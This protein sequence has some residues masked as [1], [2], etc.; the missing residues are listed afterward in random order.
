MKKITSKQDLR[1]WLEYEKLNP[2]SLW[3][4]VWVNEKQ[5]I[6]KYQKLLRK[7]EY[8]LNTN[9]RIRSLLYRFR[10]SRYQ[11]KYPLSISPNTCGKGLRIIHV[12][13]ILINGNAVVGENC[14]F[15]INTALV[16]GGNTDDTPTLGNNVIM[17]IGSTVVGGVTVAD[18]VVIGAGAVVTRDV[19]EPN[20]TVAGVPARKISDGSSAG[21]KPENRKKQS[22]E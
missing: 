11:R 7:T 5:V 18:G 19:L 6:R 12:G 20:I 16:A 3:D 4:I 2:K 13:S 22:A 17:G 14:S 9:K 21:W 10:L 8:Y 1:E 15:H